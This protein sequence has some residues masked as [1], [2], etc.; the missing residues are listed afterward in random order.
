MRRHAHLRRFTRTGWEKVEI[1]TEATYIPLKIREV[2]ETEANE[3][4]GSEDRR[5]A[6]VSSPPCFHGFLPK[7][8]FLDVLACQWILHPLIG[9]W[10]VSFKILTESFLNP[11]FCYRRM[12]RE[13]RRSEPRVGERVPYVVVYGSPGLPLIQLVRRSVYHLAYFIFCDYYLGFIG[14]LNNCKK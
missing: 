14:W 4:T 12:L 2:R 13:D 3:I 8:L 11:R 5:V 1:A 7:C 9:F 6:S 10:N